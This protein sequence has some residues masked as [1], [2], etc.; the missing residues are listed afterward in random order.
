MKK[1]PFTRNIG[2]SLSIAVILVLSGRSA[3]SRAIGRPDG[4]LLGNWLGAL[5]N[6]V[7]VYYQVSE[8]RDGS[9]MA[10]NG[11]LEFKLSGGPVEVV[12]LNRD[13]VRFEELESNQ[14]YV[15]ILN[16]D[17][18]TVHGEYSNLNIGKSWPLTLRRVDSLPLPPRPQ[19]P[20]KPYPYD[21]EQVV[22]EN[23][24][25]GIHIE[26]TLTTPGW[27]NRCPAVLLI[28]GSG[29]QNRDEE[30]AFHHP[31]WVLADFLTRRGIA[32]LRADDR[33]VGGTTR[34]GPFFNSTTRDFAG[35]AISG[36]RYLKTRKEIDPQKIGLIGHSEGGLIASM[37]AAETSEIAFIVL[38][39]SPAGGRFSDGIVSQDST[40]ARAKGASDRETA[41]IMNW[42]RRFYDVASN[43]KDKNIARNKMR[44]LVDE[45]TGEEK[46]AFGKTGLAGGT[47]DIDYALQ[48]HFQYLLSLNPDDF[49]KRVRCP[50]L[51]LMGDKDT[52]GPTASVL[53]A[54][55]TAF[56]T[57]GNKH[58]KI[59]EMKNLNHHFQTVD[60][61]NIQNSGD[62][63]ETISPAALNLIAA[64]IAGQ[65]QNR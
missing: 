41:V 48:P 40:E 4:I 20:K 62:I 36:V 21:E 51:A 34:F 28:T 22:Y 26:G 38:M 5:N 57:G 45:R 56:K 52:S 37:L 12:S 33:G 47:L 23:P 59:Q 44:R 1:S 61:G 15:G 32:V 7:H 53:K 24:S 35:D 19:T 43:E 13:T 31:F 6:E 46:E 11:I 58:F 30:S 18:L 16:R 3:P 55:E 27:K 25:A 54:M 9:F 63:E 60:P 64:W 10:Y 50:A 29:Q 49:L 14:R 17:S 65:T 42:C 39:A 2:G 8:K